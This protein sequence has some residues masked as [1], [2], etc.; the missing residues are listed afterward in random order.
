MFPLPPIDEQRQIVAETEQRLSLID[1]LSAEVAR[2][3]SHSA[4]LRRSILGLAFT[5]R[6][7]SQDPAD[8]PAS[9]LLKRIA[10]ARESEPKVARRRR[11]VPA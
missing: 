6:L 11:K 5:G 3:M 2:A 9:V 8:E 7:V 1:V 10:A 4:V